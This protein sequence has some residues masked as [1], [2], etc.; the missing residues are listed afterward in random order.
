MGKKRQKFR[1]TSEGEAVLLEGEVSAI[2]DMSPEDSK[3]MS[4]AEALQESLLLQE[5]SAGPGNFYPGS[6]FIQGSSFMGLTRLFGAK[7]SKPKYVGPAA[8]L[9]E[10]EDRIKAETAEKDDDDKAVEPAGKASTEF[11]RGDSVQ[12]FMPHAFQT[13]VQLIVKTKP[14]IL[15]SPQAYDDM[16]HIGSWSGSDEIGWLGTVVQTGNFEFLIK[17]IY[18]VGQE[19]HGSTTKITEDGLA[20]LVAEYPDINEELR[21]WGHVHPGNS[22]DPSPQDETQMDMF[23]YNE[24]FIRGIFGRQG[25]AEFT[26]F[27]YKRGLVF[28]DCPWRKISVEDDARKQYWK[29]QVAKYVQKTSSFVSTTKYAWQNQNNQSKGHIP[30]YANGYRPVETRPV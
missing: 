23:T 3:A 5:H 22:T 7:G 27:D 21:F 29:E 1:Y 19:V 24:W 26:L 8:T 18:L 20:E 13:K 15:I 10:A 25:R 4:E 16:V 12:S 11:L 30:S 9:S 14:Q 17:E 28:R 2:D 6:G